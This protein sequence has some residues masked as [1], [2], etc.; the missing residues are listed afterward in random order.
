MTKPVSVALLFGGQSFEHEVSLLSAR[1]LLNAI[2]SI[3][4]KFILVGI[5]KDGVWRLG[6]EIKSPPRS[7]TEIA[8]LPGSRGKI[9]NAESCQI[10]DRV[11]VVFP[12]VHGPL[13]EDGSLQGALKLA[14]VAFVGSSVA[15]SA[16]CMDKDICKQLLNSANIPSAKYICVSRQTIPEPQEIQSLLGFPVFVKPANMG[17]SVGVTKASSLKQ[18]DQAISFAFEYDNR[19]IIEQYIAGTEIE[20]AVL[21]RNGFEV[22]EPGQIIPSNKFD[23]YSYESK[24]TDANGAKCVIPADIPVGI[25]KQVQTMSINACKALHCEGLVRVD[26]FLTEDGELL[27][28]EL[29]TLPG[30]TDNS[31]FPKLWQESGISSGD[32]VRYLIDDALV[33]FTDENRIRNSSNTHLRY[34]PTTDCR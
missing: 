29:N 34:Q 21:S 26:M 13:C 19:I 28:N 8:L 9:I 14:N 6:S 15:S 22:S 27:V 23:F 12:A 4:Y 33:R 25:A 3:G 17:S 5:D 30:F 1:F 10:I 32:L 24:Y 18:L 7:W 20:C 11:D 16:I 31:M 2:Q